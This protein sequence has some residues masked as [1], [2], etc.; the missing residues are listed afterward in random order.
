MPAFDR[1][2]KRYLH[3]DVE[4]RRIGDLGTDLVKLTDLGNKLLV[5]LDALPAYT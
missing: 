5:E 4:R 2:V 1:G 3:V